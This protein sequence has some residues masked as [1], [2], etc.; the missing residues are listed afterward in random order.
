MHWDNY[1]RHTL[2]FAHTLA[3]AGFTIA[4]SSTRLGFSITRGIAGLVSAAAPA[5][6]L[7]GGLVIGGLD[8]AERA[9]LAPLFLGEYITTTSLL[10]AH[11]SLNV[12]SVVLPGSSE[13]SFSLA[14]IITLVKQEWNTDDESGMPET[15]YGVVQVARA[16]VAWVA[17]QGVTAEWDEARWLKHLREIHV[18]NPPK[19]SDTI[20]RRRGSRI[21]VTSDVTLPGNIGHIM[22]A[23]IGEAPPRAQSIFLHPNRPTKA[24]PVRRPL[25]PGPFLMKSSPAPLP[26]HQLKATLRRLSKLVLAGYGGASLLF[27]GVPLSSTPSMD[28]KRTEKEEEEQL[29]R[30]VIAAEAEGDHADW[31]DLAGVD[32]REPVAPPS[33]SWWDVLLGKHDTDIFHSYAAANHFTTS[34][35]STSSIAKVD[36]KA[37]MEHLM[38]RFWILTD[39]TRREVVLVLRGTMSLNELVVDLTC[40]EAPF[41]PADCTIS[42]EDDD[43][44]QM[45]V[46]GRFTF[47]KPK[48]ESTNSEPRYR[49]HGGMLKMARAMGAPGGPVHVAVREALMNSIDYGMAH[50]LTRCIACF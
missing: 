14:S 17:L 47:P 33:Y 29:A 49:V 39:H 15:Q 45:E 13:A 36:L 43:E 1:G 40:A 4:K 10:L 37:G 23:D 28:A 2:D 24:L 6:G 8:L 34:S 35:T 25:A 7:L 32:T 48:P 42:P 22:A 16:L 50:D 44:E 26:P 38:P 5:G 21:R 31:V 3:S 20:R 12:L 30:A 19:D 9:T 11:S 41:E 46:P 27:F 18:R